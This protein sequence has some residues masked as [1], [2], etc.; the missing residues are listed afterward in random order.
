[1]AANYLLIIPHTINWE[2]GYVNDPADSGGATNRGITYTTYSSLCKTVL[3]VNPSLSH[4]KTL[5]KE[6]AAMFIKY[7]WDKATGNNSIKSQ[8]IAESMFNWHWGSGQYGLQLWQ[9][10]LNTSFGAQLTTDGIIGKE[11]IN[12][13][14]SINEKKLFQEAIRTREKFFKELAVARP[15]DSKFLRGWLNRLNAFASRY[16]NLIAVSALGAGTL[17]FLGL[18]TYY[19]INKKSSS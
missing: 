5:T 14:N 12:F 9:R 16:P 19:L 2:G 18:A 3:G 11:T 7:F 13:T 4:F 6:N 17:F 1:M 8:A 10:M 15:K